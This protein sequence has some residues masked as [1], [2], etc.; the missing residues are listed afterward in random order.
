MRKNSKEQIEY[1]TIL[2]QYHLSTFIDNKIPGI[3]QAKQRTGRP[4]RS[5][6]ERLKPKRRAYWGN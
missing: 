5:W 4:L 1:W 6:P 3:S 2:L